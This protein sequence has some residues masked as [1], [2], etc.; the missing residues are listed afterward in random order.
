[1]EELYKKAEEFQFKDTKELKHLLRQEEMIK[2]KNMRYVP[3]K[4]KTL[5]REK[6]EQAH[7]SKE[8]ALIERQKFK[9]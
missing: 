9:E 7:A 6:K 2:L 1:M 4:K 3:T 8:Q 5:T